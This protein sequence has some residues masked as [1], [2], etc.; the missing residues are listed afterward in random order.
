MTKLIITLVNDQYMLGNT[1]VGAWTIKPDGE[2]VELDRNTAP[3]PTLEP[4]IDDPN[5]EPDY[6]VYMVFVNYKPLSFR[7]KVKMVS[8]EFFT[9][10]RNESAE[11]NLLEHVKANI[12]N[13]IPAELIEKAN[14]IDAVMNTIEWQG[15][16]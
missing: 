10:K 4:Q 8:I 7:K 3:M 2:I 14:G 12:I 13:E 5:Y 1:L 15:Y 16:W 11:K 6:N 9:Q